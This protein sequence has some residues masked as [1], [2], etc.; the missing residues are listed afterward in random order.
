MFDVDGLL[1]GYGNIAPEPL[2]ELIAAGKARDYEAAHAIH[3]RLLPVTQNVYHRGSHMEGT[4]A[5]KW[6][7]VQRGILDHATVRTPL[8]PLPDGADAEIAAA[9]ALAG[10]GTVTVPA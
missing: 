2:I 9:F 10:L 8:L 5:L 4:V 3:E 6:G 7:L 1:V